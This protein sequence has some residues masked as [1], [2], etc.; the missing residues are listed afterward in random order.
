M[1]SMR[2]KWCDF[3]PALFSFSHD[4]VLI[5][6]EFWTEGER[7]SFQR[8]MSQGVWTQLCDMPGV[9]DDFPH[10]GNW[11]KAELGTRE[12]TAFLDRLRLV[13]IADYIESLPGISGRHVSFNYYSYGSGDC[14][15]T[16]DD[17]VQRGGGD[18][19]RRLALVTYLH[20]E[21]QPD[22]GGEL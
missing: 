19:V 9:R 13:C 12:R 2:A 10:S 11:S 22:W 20:D 7:Q 5:L 6:D 21:W 14:L 8:A 4:P 17:R 3:N 1:Q 15:L 16:H 18:A